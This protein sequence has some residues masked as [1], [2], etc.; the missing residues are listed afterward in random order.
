VVTGG[1]GNI[2][3]ITAGLLLSRGARVVAV[4]SSA[5]ALRWTEDV[6]GAV[7]VVGDISTEEANSAIPCN[8]RVNAVCPGLVAPPASRVLSVAARATQSLP[9]RWPG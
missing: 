2:G 5:D 7:S 4:D 8:V 1:G 9:L 3:R 6:K